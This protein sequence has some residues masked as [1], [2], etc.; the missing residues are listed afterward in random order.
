MDSG[1][2]SRSRSGRS[3]WVACSTSSAP[4]STARPLRATDHRPLVAPPGPLSEARAA[5]SVLETGIKVIDLL[6][7]FVRGGKTGL[8]GGAGWA[9]RC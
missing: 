6:C 4:R 3:A 8:F 1:G 2:P 5:E 9:R 7:P